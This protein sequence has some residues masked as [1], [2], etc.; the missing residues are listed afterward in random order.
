M[1]GAPIEASSVDG[2]PLQCAA[3]RGCVET[4]KFLLYHG[5]EVGKHNP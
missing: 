4:V 1:R 2:T 3:L 5:A